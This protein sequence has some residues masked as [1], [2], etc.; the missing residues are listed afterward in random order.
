MEAMLLHAA[1]IT[2]CS[3][4]LLHAA[5]TTRIVCPVCS[6]FPSNELPTSRYLYVVQVFSP[7]CRLLSIQPP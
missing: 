3:Q 2:L 6:W 7:L 5:C 4:A 1:C